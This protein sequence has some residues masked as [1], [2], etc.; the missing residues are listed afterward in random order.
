MQRS[1]CRAVTQW[2]TAFL[3]LF[4]SLAMARFNDTS[5]WLKLYLLIHKNRGRMLN[6][7]LQRHGRESDTPQKTDMH[8]T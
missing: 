8:T 7:K 4:P 5:A 6:N 3:F 2:H 1:E